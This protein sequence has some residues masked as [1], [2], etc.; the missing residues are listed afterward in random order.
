MNSIKSFRNTQNTFGSNTGTNNQDIVWFAIRN[1]DQI[2]M[3]NKQLGTCI[4]RV[5]VGV[6]DLTE[7][8]L[9]GCVSHARNVDW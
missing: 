6:M 8:D 3:G 4:N 1:V 9:T 7:E 2:D 5:M